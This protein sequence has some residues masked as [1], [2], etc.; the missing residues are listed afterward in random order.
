MAGQWVSVGQGRVRS[1]MNETLIVIFTGVVA[2]CT[3]LYM[4]ITGWLAWETRKMRQVQTEPRVSVQ[5]ERSEQ[6]GGGAFDLVIQN[7]GL[8][9]AKEIVFKFSG[10]PTYFVG[11]GLR[12]PI[13]EL[14]II[15]E[16]INYLA[17]GGRFSLILG[18]LVGDAFT[19]AIEQPWSVSVSYK[20]LSGSARSEEFTLDFSQFSELIIGEGDQLRKIAGHLDSIQRE[21]RHWSTGMRNIRVI[22]QS[23]GHLR[24]EREEL[25]R[26]RMSA[27][28]DSDE[29]GLNN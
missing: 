10:D 21:V 24:K 12:Q 3:L 5:L 6:V 9:P 15:R 25:R 28:V 19:R 29:G 27:S 23:I 4:V 13:D 1:E 18:W 22:T 11:N 16:G 14:P 2:V 7:E 17:P 26:R 8:G 20:N